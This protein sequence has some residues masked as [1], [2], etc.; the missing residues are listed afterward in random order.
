MVVFNLFQ[1]SSVSTCEVGRDHGASTGVK[2]EKMP[3]VCMA[4]SQG[5]EEWTSKY[6]YRAL[7]AKQKSA[8]QL[9]QRLLGSLK[10]GGT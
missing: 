8:K 6:Q 9:P 4:S 7:L 3:N 5:R 10:E 1:A 2:E